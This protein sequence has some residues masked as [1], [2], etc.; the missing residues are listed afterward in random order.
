MDDGPTGGGRPA[1]RFDRDAWDE[2]WSEVL[3]EHADQ[4]AQRPPSA[5]LTA[6]ADR[7]APGRALDAGCG[8]GSEALWLAAR[9]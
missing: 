7:L 1:P 3:R 6:A 9:G 4:L 8:H 5:Y 2:R